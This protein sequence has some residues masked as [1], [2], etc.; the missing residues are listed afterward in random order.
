MMEEES[1]LLLSEEARLQED[2]RA[3]KESLVLRKKVNSRL[4]LLMFN[5]F[6]FQKIIS[7][8]D[9]SHECIQKFREQI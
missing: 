6:H 4:L 8:N 3:F 9:Y 2:L 7:V 5:R 1:A